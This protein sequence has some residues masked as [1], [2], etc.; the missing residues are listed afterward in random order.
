M[1]SLVSGLYTQYFS[2]QQLNLLVV[3]VQGSGKTTVLERIKVTEF[4]VKS[5]IVPD[6]TTTTPGSTEGKPSAA[7]TAVGP[8]PELLRSKIFL[9]DTVEDYE[10]PVTAQRRSR[11]SRASQQA[12]QQ[13]P[14][15]SRFSWI[16]PAP[17]KYRQA[18]LDTSNRDYS[19]DPLEFEDDDDDYYN[20]FSTQDESDDDSDSV[21]E[22]ASLKEK[23]PARSRIMRRTNSANNLLVPSTTSDHRRQRQQSNITKNSSLLGS[24]SAHGGGPLGLPAP[25]RISDRTS[26]A[27]DLRRSSMESIDLGPARPVRRRSI[28]NDKQQLPIILQPNT[29]NGRSMFQ[30]HDLQQFD[31]KQ[32]AKMLPLEKIRPTI[33]MNL[34]KTEICG[35]KVHIW[36]LGGKLQDLWERYYADADAVLFVWKLSR[37][38]VVRLNHQQLMQQAYDDDDGDDDSGHTHPVTAELQK[39]ILEQVRSAVPDDVPFAVLGNLFQSQPPYN[40]EPDVLYS[41]SQLLPHYHN[42]LQALFLANGVSGQGV[43]T[44]LEWLIST[45]KRQ[46]HIRERSAETNLAKH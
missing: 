32:G 16:C 22:S 34:A 29:N 43:K 1:F 17:P 36:D 41:T 45:A 40:C 15:K 12:Q 23:R 25:R 38:E 21:T 26:T 28:S 8:T 31:L 5:V 20:Y 44:A 11:R 27:D 42:P 6:T 4:S 10:L 46:Q 37:D 33:G 35:A 7:T 18:R 14:P 19:D 39:K 30:Q 3:G 9:H 13:H 2:P 24:I